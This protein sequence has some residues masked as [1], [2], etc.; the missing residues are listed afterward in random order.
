MRETVQQYDFI[1]AEH[2]NQRQ[3]RN[4]Q[5]LIADCHESVRF[6]NSLPMG[7]LEESLSVFRQSVF[8]MSERKA[9]PG[10]IYKL[11]ES[12]EAFA[13]RNLS[14]LSHEIY[15]AMQIVLEFMDKGMKGLLTGDLSVY[16]V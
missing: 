16:I 13:G 10:R 5:R 9:I 15:G 11:L 1:K 2:E 4:Y 3:D 8:S 6:L 7:I 14:E 12:D